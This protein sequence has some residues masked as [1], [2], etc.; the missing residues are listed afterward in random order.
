MT[1]GRRQDTEKIDFGKLIECPEC[2]L[3]EIV[4]VKLESHG[5]RVAFTVDTLLKTFDFNVPYLPPETT[6]CSITVTPI[7]WIE[8]GST[9]NTCLKDTS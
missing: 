5:P 3:S 7:Q 8:N 4:A 6:L 9:S 1:C 2:G